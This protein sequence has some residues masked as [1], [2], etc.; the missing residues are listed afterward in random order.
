[1]KRRL[2]RFVRPSIGLALSLVLLGCGGAPEESGSEAQGGCDP[3]APASLTIA[4]VASFSPGEGAGFGQDMFPDV[5]FGEPRGGGLSDGGL[6]VLSL[7]KGGEIVVGF[8]GTAITDG[9]GPDFIVFENAFFVGG[10]PMKPFKELGEVSA[11]EDG[12]T[13]VA[14]PCS[15][16]AYPFEGCAG[17]R[18]VFANPESGVSAFDPEA[19]GGDPFDL[20]AIGLASARLLRIRDVSDYGATPNAGFDLDAIAVVNAAP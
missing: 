10:D 18:A 7:G 3:R 17:W 14:F 9:E 19:A 11:S 8:G 6:D 1:V 5:I 13:F 12:E 15:K 20:A 2:L 4:C 16:D